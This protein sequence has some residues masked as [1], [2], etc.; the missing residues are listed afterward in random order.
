MKNLMERSYMEQ[1]IISDELYKSLFDQ[2]VSGFFIIRFVIDGNN[3]TDAIILKA[4][5]A[6][7]NQVG[8]K[9]DELEGRMYKKVFKKHR[10]DLFEQFVKV[11]KS[12]KPFIAKEYSRQIDKMIK[13]SVYRFGSGMVAVITDDISQQEKAESALMQN[14]KRFRNLYNH[15]IAG[16]TINR[17]IRHTPSETTAIVRDVNPA[18]EK[19]M[20]KSAS[21]IIQNELSVVYPV[22]DSKLVKQMIRSTSR[23]EN[24]ETEV[25]AKD[26][27]K[28]FQLTA[29]PLDKNHFVMTTQDISFVRKESLASRHLASIVESSED[30]IYSVSLNG[31]I[32]TWNNASERFYGYKEKEIVGKDVS[33][34]SHDFNHDK[35]MALIGEV[36]KGKKLTNLELIQLTKK[37]KKVPVYLSKSPIYD[38]RGKITGV[39]DIVKDISGI[40]KREME[41]IRARDKSEKAAQLKTA[42]LQNVSHEIRTPMNSILGFADILKNRINDEQHLKYLQTIEQSGKLLIDLID[43]ILDISRID[44]GDLTIEKSVFN[45]NDLLV[46][47]KS[48]FVGIK[49]KNGKAFI[50]FD[51]ILPDSKQKSFIKTDRQRLQQILDNLV[52]NAF[53]YTIK[54]SVQFGYRQYKDELM[55]FVKDTGIGIEKKHLGKIFERFMRVQEENQ[56]VFRGT[57]LGLSITKGLVEKLGGKIWCD[58]WLGEGSTFYFTLPFDTNVRPETDNSTQIQVEDNVPDLSGKTILIA[59]DDSYSFMMMKVMLEPTGAKIVHA[60]DGETAIQIYTNE[61]IHLA[62]LDIRLP[63][64][65]GYE[66]IKYIRKKNKSL[67]VIAQTAYALQEEKQKSLDAGFN[68]HLAK[69]V[70]S[71]T[72][73][74][75]I[76]KV[77]K[78]KLD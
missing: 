73:Y 76:N 14:E 52:S 64:K 23:G 62:M 43:D 20:A 74:S 16:V 69:P 66:I 12:G 53:K 60:A 18:F 4:N 77:L 34:L 56:E 19:I 25:Y 7:C 41:L 45:L 3:E 58:S 6:Y 11:E 28:Y 22:C 32:E 17:I 30:A 51:L 75:T 31:T 9:K 50:E 78:N 59:E 55:F 10:N 8:M 72:L 21:E 27:D 47:I 63:K 5:Q 67:P 68:A 49:D 13:L 39:S 15:M 26:D 2:L 71:S 48:R 38:E 33:I 1:E 24:Y 35:H 44:T 61:P 70:T 46:E 42:F 40:K 54:G 57:G 37:G 36:M 29:F 65:D